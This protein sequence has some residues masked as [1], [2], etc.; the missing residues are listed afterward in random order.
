M[1]EALALKYRVLTPVRFG[2]GALL[3]LTEAQLRGRQHA[4]KAAAKGLHQVVTEVQFKR[5]EELVIAGDVPKVLAN[6]LQPLS[7]RAA[8]AARAAASATAAATA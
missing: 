5:G 6:A 3:G 4:L 8:A 2:A 7:G 1:S